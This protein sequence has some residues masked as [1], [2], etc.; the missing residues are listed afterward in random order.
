MTASSQD[1]ADDTIASAPPQPGCEAAERTEFWTTL[2]TELEAWR[3]S[4]R[5]A[6]FFWRDDDAV[7][8]TR[9]LDRL[10]AA[11]AAFG[12]P[13]ALAVI[14]AQLSAGLPR[15][16]A[17]E[18]QV[19]VVQHGFAHLNHAQ[20]LGGGASELGIERPAKIVLGELAD[21]RARLEAAFGAR[22]VPVLAPPWNKIA[23][24]LVPS[25]PRIGFTAV[26]A[27]GR[28]ASAAP[29]PGLTQ[30]NIHWDLIAWKRGARF[31][32]YESAR[33]IINH[34]R[35]R[36]SGDVDPDEPTG[37]LT[38]HLRMDE[39]AWRFLRRFLEA[40]SAH[41]AASWCDPTE[42]GRRAA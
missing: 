12:V 37:I 13:F 1:V 8:P 31:R 38:H 27:A 9:A 20:G 28:R 11:S 3:S 17:R 4:G 30:V 24:T 32:G 42:F 26:S 29:E 39:E 25:L 19:R 33:G 18:R 7:A 15:R 21:G 34:L 5:H 23:E 16:V 2:R 14:P 22:F 35:A 10:L 6:T 40:T 36:R 41:D